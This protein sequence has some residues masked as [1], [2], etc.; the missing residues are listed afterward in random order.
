MWCKL[1]ECMKSKYYKF[2]FREGDIV[3]F[4]QPL[5]TFHKGHTDLF[6]CQFNTGTGVVIKI[7]KHR[8]HVSISRGELIE[9]NSVS[10]YIQVIDRK[11]RK[12]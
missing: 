5:H 3:R 11:R 9:L 10:D 4:C 2:K 7:S 6:V 12:K 1:G 8:L